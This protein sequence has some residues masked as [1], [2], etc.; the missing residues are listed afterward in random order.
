MATTAVLLAPGVYRIP[1]MRDFINSYAFIDDDGQVTLVDAGLK[2]APK[3]IV[4]GLASIGKHPKDVTRIILTHAHNDH[5]G[6]ANE[7]VR[8]TGLTG[9]SAHEQDAEYIRQGVRAPI[10]PTQ[11]SARIFGRLSKGGFAATSIAEVLTDGQV[12]DVA[13][14]ITVHHTPGHSPGHVSLMHE[15]SGVLIT[16]DAIFNMNAKMRWPFAAFCTSF[17]QNQRSAQILGDLEYRIAAF[18]HGPEIRD[19]AREAIRGFL[20]KQ[21]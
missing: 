13:G 18:T 16:G 1:T 3:K 8:T 20:R 6:G 2:R 7:M 15:P 10:D 14:G 5:A 19:N 11:S 21:A 12:I 9:V 17:T 4:E